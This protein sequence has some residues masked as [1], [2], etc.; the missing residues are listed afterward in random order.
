MA[1]QVKVINPVTILQNLDTPQSYQSRNIDRTFFNK[2][3]FPSKE[4]LIGKKTIEVRLKGQVSENILQNNIRGY[5]NFLGSMGFADISADKSKNEIKVK[6]YTIKFLKYKPPQKNIPTAILEKGSILIFNKSLENKKTFKSANDI[7]NDNDTMNELKK[8]FK[9]WGE[10]PTSWIDSY[11]KQQKKLFE[12]IGTDGWETIQYNERDSFMNFIKNQVLRKIY[13]KRYS[14]WNP[15]DIWVIKENRREQIKQILKNVADQKTKK[16]KDISLERLNDILSDLLVKNELIG[17]SLKKIKGEPRLVYVNVR[18]QHINFVKDLLDEE[19]EVAEKDIKIE[20]DLFSSSREYKEECRVK[21]KGNNSIQIKSN[22]G[23][24]SSSPNLNLKF[25][26]NLG[27]S[28]GRGGKIEIKLIEEQVKKFENNY[29]IYPSTKS[30]FQKERVDYEKYFNEIKSKLSFNSD[31]FNGK[32]FADEIEKMF[33]SQDKK[34]VRI[35]QIKLMEL[36]FLREM[37]K[38]TSKPNNNLG[39]FWTEILYSSMKKN[40]KG[41]NFFA[42]HGKLY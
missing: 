34:T 26:S 10:V 35:A 14:T 17:V 4:S 24:K 20:F 37:Y 16:E 27:T 31:T 36:K 25:E 28:G 12:V 39:E 42:P 2:L 1:T 5:V 21:F 19:Y 29:K 33:D 7:T 41:Q 15:S 40:R 8:I 38:L 18:P 9:P 32:D 30:I 3:S 22:A 13:N 23:A 6:T 11:Y